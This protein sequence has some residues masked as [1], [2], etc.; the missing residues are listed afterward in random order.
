MALE[1]TLVLVK[2]DGVQRGL[3]GE[4]L[5]RFERKGVK[6]VGLKLVHVGKELAERNYAVHKGKPFYEGLVKYIGAAPVAAMVLEGESI[7]KVVRSL[8][9]PTNPVEGKPGELRFDFTQHIGRNLIHASDS[10]ENAK[11]EI[12]LWFEHDELVE[13]KR[14]DAA[15]VFE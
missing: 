10:V 12:A 2:P 5:A 11:G 3:V 14:H 13:W 15:W 9:G 1:R 7:V 8:V 4:V 6:L